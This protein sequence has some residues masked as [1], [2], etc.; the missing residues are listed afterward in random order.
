MSSTAGDFRNLTRLVLATALNR[1]GTTVCEPIHRFD[2]EAPQASL[3]SVLALLAKV[4]AIP[5]S[6][7]PRPPSVVLS[8]TV[9]AGEVHRLFT[10]LPGETRGE[11]VLTTALDHHRPVAGPRP[12]SPRRDQN[13]YDR[14]EY[15]RR[16]TRRTTT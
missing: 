5:V 4:G 12:R 3:P 10:L 13:P 6:T 7:E 2:L 11:G 15:L 16:V 14:E 1:A 9:P 8:G